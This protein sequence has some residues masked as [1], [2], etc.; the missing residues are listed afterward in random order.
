M[1]R[2]TWRVVGG[3]VLTLANTVLHAQPEG[4]LPPQLEGFVPLGQVPPSDQLPA[5][6]LLIAAYAFV[7]MAVLG[8]VGV[9][10]RKVTRATDELSQLRQRQN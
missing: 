2:S 5:A 7:W 10:W 4:T 6:P 1:R 8:F 9:T 3:L